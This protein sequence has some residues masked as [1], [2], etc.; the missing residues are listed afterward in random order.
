MTDTKTTIKSEGIFAFLHDRYFQTVELDRPQD[1]VL[2]GK[3]PVHQGD[4]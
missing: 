3:L 2:A 1:V 4:L